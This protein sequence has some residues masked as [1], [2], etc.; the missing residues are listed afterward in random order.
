MVLQLDG[1]LGEDG[2]VPIVALLIQATSRVGRRGDAAFTIGAL[3]GVSVVLAAF[4]WSVK[5]EHDYL[6]LYREKVDP[7]LP[8]QRE[9]GERYRA[10]PGSFFLEAFQNAR[11]LSD[12]MDRPQSDPE[13]ELARQRVVRRRPWLMRSWVACGVWYAFMAFGGR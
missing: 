4:L 6:R 1:L 12:I 11:R 8:T 3:L 2:I 7:T 9:L 5:A 10:Y 13:V